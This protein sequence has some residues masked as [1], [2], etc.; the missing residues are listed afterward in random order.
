M[1]NFLCPMFVGISPKTGKVILLSK[2]RK[3][4]R[5]DWNSEMATLFTGENNVDQSDKQRS[6]IRSGD[7]LEKNW[8]ATGGHLGSSYLCL[9][10]N[11]RI[12]SLV[13]RHSLQSACIPP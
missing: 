1:L 4:M 13:I 2:N 3:Q 12:Y 9:Y 7:T 5:R 8:V 10:K 6:K 11:E